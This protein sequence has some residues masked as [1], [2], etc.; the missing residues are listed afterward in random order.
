LSLISPLY[1]TTGL[2]KM[3]LGLEIYKNQV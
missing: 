1:L 3:V 2:F